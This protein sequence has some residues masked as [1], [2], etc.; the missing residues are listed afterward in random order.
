[1]HQL[2]DFAISI[3][4]CAMC[5][6]G[7][8]YPDIDEAYRHLHTFHGQDSGPLTEAQ[9]IKL[10][11][12][13]LSTA[14][15]ELERRNIEMIK[16]VQALHHRAAKLLNKAIKIR[17]SVVNEKG[18]KD[19]RFLL[20]SALVKAA[21]RIFQFIYTARYTAQYLREQNKKII[22]PSSTSSIGVFD[23]LALAEYYGIAAESEL[24]KAQ[25]E[26]LLMAHT[27]ASDGASVVQY[28]SST[29]ETTTVFAIFC[30][31]GKHLH[32]DKSL[33]ELYRAH[34]S[35]LVSSTIS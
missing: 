11:H 10:G 19:P 28:I 15:M 9:R 14:G 7:N 35:T 12:W 2:T 1:M 13:L 24:S 6:R 4:A 32:Q 22:A 26:L 23:N 33:P 30:L 16:L 27:G 29:P 25:N 17:N 3:E 18:E 31:M 5:S 21:Q 8:L 34:L 20:P